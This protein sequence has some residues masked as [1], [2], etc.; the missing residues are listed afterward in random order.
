MIESFF[1][2]IAYQP[3]FN[4][5]SRLHYPC[6]KVTGNEV[7]YFKN[8]EDA[9]SFIKKTYI[10]YNKSPF[11]DVLWYYAFVVVELP[12]GTT[13]KTDDYL[14]LRIYLS[15]GTLWGQNT[16][17]NFMPDGRYSDLEYEWWEKKQAFCGRDPNE[18]RFKQGDIVEVLGCHGNDFWSH[19]EVNLSIIV[20]SPKTKEQISSK[21]KEDNEAA[22]CGRY[23]DNYELLSFACEALDHAPTICVLPP[24]K[25]V[26]ERRRQKLQELLDKYKKEQ[27]SR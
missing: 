19:N 11:E 25:P 8:L 7:S 24:I 4:K 16:Y 2:V 21:R 13:L 26:S 5:I 1:K 15:D 23:E 20:N 14:S 27:E 17:C 3:H 18:I 12:F 10:K 9:E 22:L 6:F